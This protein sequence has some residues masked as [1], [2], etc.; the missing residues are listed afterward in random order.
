MFTC[1]FC[2]YCIFCTFSKGYIKIK[3]VYWVISFVFREIHYSSPPDYVEEDVQL[4]LLTPNSFMFLQPV[5]PLESDSHHVQETTLKRRV[6]YLSKVKDSLWILRLSDSGN[7]KRL[8][9]KTHLRMFFPNWTRN[10]AITRTNKF[11][12]TTLSNV[13]IGC[14]EQ[15]PPTETN[16]GGNQTCNEM[17]SRKGF[18]AFDN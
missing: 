5:A 14:V 15:L 13:L 17:K 4:P 10:H 16:E 12:F 9:L 11:H 3:R 7:F 8:L 2:D 1:A 6:R 18:D